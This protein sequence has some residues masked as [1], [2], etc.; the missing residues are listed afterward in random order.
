[1]PA[2]ILSD[3][4]DSIDS[5]QCD[6]TDLV[7]KVA[8]GNIDPLDIRSHLAIIALRIDGIAKMLETYNAAI[9]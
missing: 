7:G 5:I 1:M 2:A 8:T 3:V 4:I 9:A 6:I